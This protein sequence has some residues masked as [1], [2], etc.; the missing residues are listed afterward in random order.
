MAGTKLA[1]VTG[2]SS[3]IGLVMAKLFAADG[4]DFAV[5]TSSPMPGSPQTLTNAK[6]P[7]SVKALAAE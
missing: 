1:L 4:Y 6:L 3:G 7:D 5:A 2:A